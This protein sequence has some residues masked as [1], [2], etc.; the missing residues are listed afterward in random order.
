MYGITFIELAIVLVIA[1][2]VLVPI[3]AF[4]VLAV[5][6]LKALRAGRAGHATL[7]CPHC[8]AQTPAGDSQCRHCGKQLS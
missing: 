1:V 8:H 6:G 2:L 3:V 5:F 7:N 4:I